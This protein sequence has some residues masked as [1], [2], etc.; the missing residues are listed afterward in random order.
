M[1]YKKFALYFKRIDQIVYDLLIHSYRLIL[2][3]LILLII[4]GQIIKRTAHT[5]IQIYRLDHKLFW[6]TRY[7]YIKSF[8]FSLYQPFLYD[9][10]KEI[11]L[12]L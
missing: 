12:D 11:G 9:R 8:V 10:K 3:I 7:K 4:C 2:L 1:A 5:K 6:T